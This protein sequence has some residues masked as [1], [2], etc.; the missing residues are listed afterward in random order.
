M[1]SHYDLSDDE[2]AQQFEACTLVPQLFNHVAHLRLAW[3]H[4]RQFGAEQ[5]AMNLCTQIKRFDAT[6]DD[7]TKFNTTVTVAAVKA[8]NHFMEQS[9]TTTFPDFIAENPRLQTDFK[10]LLA[11]HY[12]FDVFTHPAAKQSFVAPDLASF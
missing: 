1:P 12:S 4:I 9:A 6:F 3:I 11:S 5:A 7:G 8:V 2:F 10:G